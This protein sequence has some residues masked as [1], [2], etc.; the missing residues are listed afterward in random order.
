MGHTEIIAQNESLV[1]RNAGEGRA[2]KSGRILLGACALGLVLAGLTIA[3]FGMTTVFVPSDLG[4]VGLGPQTLARISPMLILLIAHDRA[5]FGAGLCSE[6]CLLLFMA[7]R[8]ELNRSLVEIVAAMGISGF[9]AAT[10][11]HFAVGY[12]DFL[13]LLPG[14]AGFGLF[15]AANSLL[16]IGWRNLRAIPASESQPDLT[17]S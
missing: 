5:G 17:V 15:L 4:F 12:V 7:R 3:I 16:Y 9:G 6:G 8:A 11:V 1:L 13:H 10:A 2:A 14:F